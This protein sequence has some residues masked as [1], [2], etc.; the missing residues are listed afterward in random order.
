[1]DLSS[2][3]DEAG[4]SDNNPAVVKA[5]GTLAASGRD[6]SGSGQETEAEAARRTV[7]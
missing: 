4:Q 3:G 1:M 5:V 7:S 2:F 6:V